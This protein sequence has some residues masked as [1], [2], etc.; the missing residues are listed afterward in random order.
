M[1]N[2]FYLEILLLLKTYMI[3]H[4]FSKDSSLKPNLSLK[5]FL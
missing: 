2:N 4:V 1:T 5:A 3:M